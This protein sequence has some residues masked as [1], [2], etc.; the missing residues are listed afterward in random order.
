ML[1]LVVVGNFFLVC[2][3]MHDTVLWLF[4]IHVMKY[5]LLAFIKI[6][7]RFNL[8]VTF[9]SSALLKA[10]SHFRRAFNAIFSTFFGE[11]K[12]FAKNKEKDANDHKKT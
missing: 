3:L 4:R 6:L 10:I 7:V 5:D 8:C 12:L 9:A 2:A 1:L 11:L